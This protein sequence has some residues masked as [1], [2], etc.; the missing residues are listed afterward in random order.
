MLPKRSRQISVRIDAETFAKLDAFCATNHWWKRNAVINQILT[1]VLNEFNIKQISN[2]M[3][4][5]KPRGRHY[6]VEFKEE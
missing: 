6:E 5:W 1:A 4:Y 3:G 2:M